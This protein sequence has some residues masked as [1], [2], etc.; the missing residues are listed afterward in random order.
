MSFEDISVALV[1]MA[2]E[3]QSLS[4]ALE[5]ALDRLEDIEDK[6]HDLTRGEIDEKT[7]AT[8]LRYPYP[9]RIQEQWNS[10]FNRETPS[11]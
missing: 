7:L 5:E 10:R 3:L 11:L 6:L 2:R 8:T 1:E 9:S 4:E